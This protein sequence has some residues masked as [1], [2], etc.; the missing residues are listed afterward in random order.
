MHIRIIELS[1]DSNRRDSHFPHKIGYLSLMDTNRQT[2]HQSRLHI[3]R[4]HSW[5]CILCRNLGFA[6]WNE[7]RGNTAGACF[8]FSFAETLHV[9]MLKTNGEKRKACETALSFQP[10]D[11]TN[12]KFGF[13]FWSLWCTAHSCAPTYLWFLCISEVKNC[14]HNNSRLISGYAWVLL[15]Y[16]FDEEAN[17]DVCLMIISI[18]QV[19]L[20]AFCLKLL[21]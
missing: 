1:L 9:Q 15:A 6:P 14:C 20:N 10:A 21:L 2:F 8:V 12:F 16:L 4:A 7:V 17:Y 13:A 11:K 5:S 19:T 18:N 3:S